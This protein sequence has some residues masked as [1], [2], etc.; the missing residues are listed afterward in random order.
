MTGTAGAVS[1]V[2]VE[3]GTLNHSGWTLTNVSK[4]MSSTFTVTGWTQNNVH[5]W[6][7]TNK[8]SNVNNTN[9]VDYLWVVSS[10]PIL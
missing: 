5:H 2:L 8:T 10:V 1:K 6:D 4:K 9:R 3:Q 7:T